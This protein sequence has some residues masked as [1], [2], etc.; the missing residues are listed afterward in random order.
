MD[1][2]MAHEANCGNQTIQANCAAFVN[3][4]FHIFKFCSS[5]H[6]IQFSTCAAVLFNFQFSITAEVFIKVDIEQFFF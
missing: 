3:L 5:V 4:Q 1:L 2:L 6:K